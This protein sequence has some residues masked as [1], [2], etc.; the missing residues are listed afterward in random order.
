[1]GQILHPGQDAGSRCGKAGD[2]FKQ[3]IRKTGDL[4]RK[5]K[6]QRANQAH[7]NPSKRNPH[8]PFPRIELRIFR[9]LE[10]KSC[11][12]DK[13]QQCTGQK[14]RPCLFSVKKRHGQRKEEEYALHL[15]DPAEYIA[16]TFVIHGY[17]C[18]F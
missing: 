13:G 11:P 18:S 6:W 4:T 5:I 17:D 2:D 16:N 14:N 3:G 15:H 8:I 9:S 7:H 1:M 12:K 10:G